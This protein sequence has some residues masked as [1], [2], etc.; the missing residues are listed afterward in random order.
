M[1]FVT[2]TKEEFEKFLPKDFTVVDNPQSKE[3]IYDFPTKDSRINLRVYSSV[4]IRTNDTRGIGK[5]AIRCVLIDTKSDKPIDKGKRT[6]RMENW[7]ER[8]QEKL[9]LLQS[10]VDGVKFCRSCGSAM[11]LRT[12]KKG[13]NSGSSFYGCLRYPLCMTTM[14]TEGKVRER[15]ESGSKQSSNNEPQKVVLC[16]R[17]NSRMVKRSGTRGEFYGCTQFRTS[18]CRGTR[19][20]DDVEIRG[21]GVQEAVENKK[22]K[23]RTETADSILS[24]YEETNSN[25]DVPHNDDNIKLIPTKDFP[26]MSFK[27]ENFNPVQSRVFQYYDKDINLVVA[28]ATSAGKTTIAEMLMSDSISKGKKA[29]FLSPLKAVSQE[30]NDD[31]NDKSHDWSN[32]NVSIVTGDYQ[33]TE[34]RVKEL[35]SAN[36][37][38]MTTEMMDSR[39]RRIKTEKNDWLLEVGTVVVDESHLITMDGRGDKVESAIMRFT[40]QNP[41]CRVVFLS[42]TMPNVSEL[43][44]WL[45]SLNGKKTELINSN[46]R[47]CNLDVHYEEY[48]SGGLRYRE[49]EA[50]KM[51][52]AIS[53]TQQY[54]NDKFIIFVHAKNTGRTIHHILKEEYNENVE[55][56]NAE[57]TLADRIR[58]SNS[59]KKKDGIRIIVATSTLAWGVNL[60]ARRV[61]IVGVHRGLNT[62]EPLD[63]KQEAGRAG[64]VGF[65]PKGDAHILLPDDKYNYYKKWCQDIPPITSRMNNPDILAFHIVSEI[66][67]G[68]VYDVSTLM[69]WYNRSLAAFQSDMLDRVD[70]ETLLEKLEKIKIIE[71]IN[72]RYRI[73]KLGR[74]ASNLYYSPYTIAGWYFNF[75]TIFSEELDKHDPAV[76]WALSNIRENFENYIP[77]QYEEGVKN[78]VRDCQRVGISANTDGSAWI[79]YSFLSCLRY[80]QEFPKYQKTNVQYDMERIISALEQ[81][82]QRVAAWGKGS[83]WSKLQMRIQYE[84]TWE[85]TILCELKGI[86]GAYARRLY[87]NGIHSITDFKKDS[88]AAI[89]AIGPKEYHRVLQKNNLI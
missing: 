80:D 29:I 21:M 25:V 58:V 71:N 9:D 57:L 67:A 33:L 31:W 16:P 46:Y 42:A 4:D 83:Y 1:G 48:A 12:A 51:N 81:I 8:L 27:F 69:E 52:T 64:R 26:H 61:I 73:T 66:S 88:D 37:I 84:V 62:V 19:Q 63:I 41:N 35:N 49:A 15:P 22:D 60:P 5:D 89:G 86:G 7:R 75:S 76:A 44:N 18:G 54:K 23:L 38:I 53:I 11:A 82:D 45:T 3:I 78:F 59:F 13:N 65:D 77:K 6:H 40:K 55:I 43:A 17:C 47:P 28:A 14:S 68:E 2:I 50:E 39:T 30:K 32:L 85:Q 74:I 36:V 79:G 87:E 72:G 70:A 10:E 56:H 24:G 20:V 34:K